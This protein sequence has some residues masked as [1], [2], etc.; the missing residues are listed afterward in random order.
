LFCF[1]FLKFQEIFNHYRIFETGISND[2][3]PDI[4]Y[5]EFLIREAEKKAKLKQRQKELK[6]QMLVIIW[7]LRRDET[8][9]RKK[10]SGI[11]FGLNGLGKRFGTQGVYY[12]GSNP[13]SRALSSSYVLT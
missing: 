6:F 1:S 7:T 4:E 5:N 13:L 11:N 3:K 9:S 10:T 8:S 12:R 2:I